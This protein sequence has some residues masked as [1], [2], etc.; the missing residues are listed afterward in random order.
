[1]KENIIYTKTDIIKTFSEL[2]HKP[3]FKLTKNGDLQISLLGLCVVYE[4]K[5]GTFKNK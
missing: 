2:Y 1:M 5:K 3:N 4:F